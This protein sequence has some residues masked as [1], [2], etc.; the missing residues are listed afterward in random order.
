M[1]SKDDDRGNQ[2]PGLEGAKYFAAKRMNAYKY[3]VELN[4]FFFIGGLPHHKF[5]KVV[6]P[7]S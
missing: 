3:L 7:L 4:N 2:F 5:R 6:R 1:E